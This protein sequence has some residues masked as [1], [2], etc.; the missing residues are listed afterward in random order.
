M[1][2]SVFLKANNQGWETASLSS[3]RPKTN[4]K[5]LCLSSMT[6][7]KEHYRKMPKTDMAAEPIYSLDRIIENK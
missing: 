6:G 5:K 4:T 2:K 7:K 3:Y 1:G